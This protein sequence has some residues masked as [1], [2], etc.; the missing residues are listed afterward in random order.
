MADKENKFE[1]FAPESSDVEQYVYG[2]DAQTGRTYESLTQK[3]RNAVD[4]IVE[5]GITTDSETIA[6]E[7]GISDSYVSY[8]KENFP[9]IVNNRRGANLVSAD[10]GEEMYTIQ[11]PATDVWKAIRLLPQ[12]LSESIFKQVRKQ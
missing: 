12:E 6:R 7:A 5:L 1:K 9:H 2:E 4:A 8:V 11:L 3:Q 10:G